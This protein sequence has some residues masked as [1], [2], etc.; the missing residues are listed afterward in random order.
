MRKTYRELMSINSFDERIRYLQTGSIIGERTF[1]SNRRMNQILYTSPEWKSIRRKVI[2]R[3]NGFDLGHEDYPI[4]GRIVIH[5]IEPIS[6]EDIYTRSYKIFDPEN[7]ISCSFHTH[8]VIHWG[9]EDDSRYK[10]VIERTPNDT[11]PWKGV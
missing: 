7:L 3:D 2:L 11:C 10:E 9:I 4:A 8:Q 5:H 1:G 6:E